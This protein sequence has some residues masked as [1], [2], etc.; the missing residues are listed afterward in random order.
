LRGAEKSL[1]RGMLECFV[2][3]VHKDQV[4]T[5]SLVEYLKSFG[6]GIDKVIGFNHVKDVV[7]L[8]LR[9]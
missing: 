2:I 4:S 8:K 7:Y 5:E 9:Q 1:G 3:E 6:Y